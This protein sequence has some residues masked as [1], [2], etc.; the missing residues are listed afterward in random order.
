VVPEDDMSRARLAYVLLPVLVGC[1]H[2]LKG[3]TPTVT[4][5]DPILVCNEVTNPATVVTLT[6][7]NLAALAEDTLTSG[8]KVVLPAIALFPA[9]GLDGNPPADSTPVPVDPSTVTWHS[10]LEMLFG[11][12][13][14]LAPGIYDVAVT[15]PDGQKAALADGLAVVPPPVVTGFQP[16]EICTAQGTRTV[17]IQGMDFLVVGGMTPSATIGGNTYPG[18]NPQGCVA[19][20]APAAAD[21]LCTSFDVSIPDGDLQPPGGYG[22]V[23]TNPAPANCSSMSP[24]PVL[25]NN[26]PPTI[27]HVQPPQ[28]C[29]TGGAVS[30]VG[31]GFLPGATVTIGTGAPI[32]DGTV[33]TDGTQIEVG[34]LPA[35]T[36]GSYDVTVTNQDMCSV[37]APGALTVVAKPLLFFVDPPVLYNGIAVQITV[38]GTG[39]NGAI[40]DVSIQQHGMPAT[41]QSLGG[42]TQDSAFPNRVQAVV[43]AG[44]TIG[45]YD[46]FIT[47][48][49]C[50]S[51]LVNAFL[52]VDQT[53]L[54]L[55]GIAPPFGFTG[56]DTAVQISAVVSSTSPGF[57]QT[58]RVYLNP[59]GG[60]GTATALFA[61][62][63]QS[64]TILDAVV[65]AA[66]N[67]APGAY[68]VI[69]V[70]PDGSVGLLPGAFTVTA[71]PPADVT[72]VTPGSVRAGAA[73]TMTVTGSALDPA[74]DVSISC[75]TTAGVQVLP[76]T[77]PTAT[78]VSMSELTFP[79]P[80]DLAAGDVCIVRVTN[81]DGSFSDFSAIGVLNSGLNLGGF[82]DSTMAGSTV[83]PLGTARRALG[84]VSGRVNATNRYLYAIG[85][86]GGTAAT[87]LSSV[88]AANV[89]LFGGLG[90]W[91]PQPNSMTTA[92]TLFGAVRVGQFVY[93]AGGTPDGATVLS[94]VERARILDPLDVPAAQIDDLTLGATGLDQGT[95]VYRVTGV[96]SPAYP[97]DP[98]GETLPSEPLNVSIPDLTTIT[99]T[100]QKVQVKLAWAPMAAGEQIGKYRIYR[101]PAAGQDVS[102]A[103]LLDEIDASASSYVDDGT[104]TPAGPGPLPIGSLGRWH[105]P[106]NTAGNPLALVKPRMGARVLAAQ[107]P[108]A[109]S[110]WVI[111]VGGGA[112]D[113]T[114]GID[115]NYEYARVG[116][117]GDGSETIAPFAL[118]TKRIGV[119]RMDLSG[120]VVDQSVKADTGPD[121]TYVYFGSGENDTGNA[122]DALVVGTLSSGSTTGELTSAATLTLDALPTDDHGTAG[123][124]SVAAAGVLFDLG[125]GGSPSTGTF[126]TQICPDKSG[127][128]SNG[129]AATP[130][131]VD[132]WNADTALQVARYLAGAVIE[133]ASIYVVGGESTA[134]PTK[135]VERTVW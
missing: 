42:L 59:T 69:V 63:E 113:T 40:T 83:T 104:K 41:L 5:V 4:A 45:E 75:Q 128:C 20:P 114:G 131:F 112:I 29:E 110:S 19:L 12:P 88:E 9:E 2:D 58:P 54:T 118:G 80:T 57:I 49:T 78:P 24:G 26:P 106:M 55:T 66:A 38:Y 129:Q 105:V 70:N 97:S 116:I 108:G 30:V 27:D 7:T 81:P 51:E 15:N 56:A 135:V 120:F 89:D 73:T 17:T 102:Q 6:G 125:G 84:L 34:T 8:T 23:V 86:D 16:P 117:A 28:I 87:A 36:P 50:T 39:V 33:S 46:L 101:T 65:P 68:D 99:T 67:L 98:G 21:Q 85:G 127:N 71:N 13:A 35:M 115:P 103:V 92:R 91:T 111:Y 47:D 11:L 130:P 133:S 74:A 37:T 126:S 77:Q 60:A 52:V 93:A 3:P 32:T 100:G 44:L 61:V 48:Q 109:P 119:A 53:N 121:T 124:A 96:H 25:T 10:Q 62:A 90:A 132:N 122:I 94:S 134:G 72:D 76:A 79:F 14:S 43:P 123:A 18:S 22:V 82:Q 107:I 31:A 64:A 1:G 95:W